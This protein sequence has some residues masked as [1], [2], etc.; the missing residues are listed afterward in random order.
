MT[1]PKSKRQ[2]LSQP[3][4]ELLGRDAEAN[5][6]SITTAAPAGTNGIQFGWYL[7]LS[8]RGKP[9]RG[10]LL[11]GS[12]YWATPVVTFGYTNG[13]SLDSRL[14]AMKCAT[15]SQG[16]PI[17][18]NQLD[19]SWQPSPDGTKNV[20]SSVTGSFDGSAAPN[21]FPQP[22]SGTDGL[23]FGFDLDDYQ[24]TFWTND[25]AVV[26][27]K[28]SA[29]G[30]IPGWPHGLVERVQSGQS[31]IL[32]TPSGISDNASRKSQSAGPRLGPAPLAQPVATTWYRKS[33][34]SRISA[35]LPMSADRE[36]FPS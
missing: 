23:D 29:P 16:K 14:H 24:Q 30:L 9:W 7:S 8:Q 28:L 25:G 4:V 18:F 15:D 22:P 34:Y 1:R 35:T 26:G 20:L 27:P 31:E 17:H 32:R 21:N 3:A 19:F 11:V 5:D 12:T 2:I 33:R 6:E 36:H 10:C 13:P